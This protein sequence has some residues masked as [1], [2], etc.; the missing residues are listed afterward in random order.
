MSNSIEV[1]NLSKSYKSK[2]AV[3]NINFKINEYE[4]VGLLG[5]NGCGKT[6]TIGMMLGLLKPTNGQVLINGM[7]I[8]KNKI[9]LLHKMNFISPYIEL[10]KK[11]TVRQNLVVY[12]K[13]YNVHN[14]NEQIDLSLIHI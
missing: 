8:E 14:L 13:L 1:I 9:S 10:P 2:Q 5:P 11:L 7:D 12:G 4:I 3:N 6:T